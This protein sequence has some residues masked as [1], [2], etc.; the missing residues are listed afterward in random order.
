MLALLTNSVMRTAAMEVL[1]L[2]FIICG[3]GEG[4]QKERKL[5][6]HAKMGSNGSCG[7]DNGLMRG[8]ISAALDAALSNKLNTG[9]ARDGNVVVYPG[10]REGQYKL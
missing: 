3:F 8:C 9:T 1:I 2:P 10:F 7:I 4:R 5:Y 6:L